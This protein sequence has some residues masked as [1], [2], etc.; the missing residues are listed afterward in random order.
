MITKIIQ[1]TSLYKKKLL[2]TGNF[3]HFSFHSIFS[4]GYCVTKCK[5]GN[6]SVA[7]VNNKK[8]LYSL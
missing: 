3:F 8:M 5:Y 1:N 4:K 2:K 6:P 7:S